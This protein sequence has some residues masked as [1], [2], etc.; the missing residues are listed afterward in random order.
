[1]RHNWGGDHLPPKPPHRVPGRVY[2][3]KDFQVEYTL[4]PV[5]GVDT[6]RRTWTHVYQE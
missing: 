3:S 6:W 4:E 5:K 1:M 2:M